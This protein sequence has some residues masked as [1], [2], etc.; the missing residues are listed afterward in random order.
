MTSVAASHVPPQRRDT[1]AS[2]VQFLRRDSLPSAATPA[3]MT[4]QRAGASVA[5]IEN[6]LTHELHCYDYV[7]QPYEIVRRA[8]LADPLELFTRATSAGRGSRLHVMLGAI[9]LGAEIEIEIRSIGEKHEPFE[10]PSLMITLAWHSRRRVALFPTLAA[11]LVVYP[12]TPTETQVE[13]TGTYDPPLGIVGEAVDA[14]VLHRFAK[15]SAAGFVR[16]IATHLRRNL[17]AAQA[18]A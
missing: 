13:L 6:M 18:T 12:L 9:E 17:S 16:E 14:A 1:T 10:R 4:Q 8:V 5:L 7:N 2:N 11:Q 15:E 3:R